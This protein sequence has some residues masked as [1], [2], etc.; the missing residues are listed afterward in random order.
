MRK[1]ATEIIEAA[2]SLSNYVYWYGGKREEC[3]YRLAQK[4]KS[5]N[6]SVWTQSYYNKARQDI[7]NGRKC[8][9]CSGLV[10]FAY[11][12]SDIGSSAMPEKF[13]TY[14]GAP[15]AGMIAWKSGHCGIFLADGWDAPIAEMRGIDYDYQETRTFKEVGFTRV[16][17]SRSVLYEYGT[18]MAVGWH[19]DA[20]GWWYRHTAGIGPKTYYHDCF[21]AINGH[22]YFF[23]GSGYICKITPTD[24]TPIPP[25]SST[26]WLE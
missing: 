26:G 24:P 22:P 6:P 19:K 3:T 20:S 21:Q 14:T 23:N 17:C 7:T 25:T 5:A 8:C 4:L 1:T 18:T 9:D 10:S 16:L 11:G 12:I 2:K 15:F 13:E